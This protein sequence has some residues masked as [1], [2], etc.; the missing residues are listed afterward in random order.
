MLRI[1]ALVFHL[2][3]LALVLVAAR[4]KNSS[5]GRSITDIIV[6][7]GMW[8]FVLVLGEPR[9]HFVVCKAANPL[10]ALVVILSAFV[11][12]ALPISLSRDAALYKYVGFLE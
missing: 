6:R 4:T 3:L 2:F 8:A 5:K 1:F 7:D 10:L 11:S 9:V 12:N